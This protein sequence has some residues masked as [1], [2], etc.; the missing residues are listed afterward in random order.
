MN[1]NGRI[2]K[3]INEDNRFEKN[4]LLE[5]VIKRV[6]RKLMTERKSDEI[7]L[8]ISRKIILSSVNSCFIFS[9]LRIKKILK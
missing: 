6:S 5:N 2:R 4:Y 8:F 9:I 7:S 1:N 3:I